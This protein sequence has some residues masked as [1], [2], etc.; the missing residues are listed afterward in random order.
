M[1]T[2]ISRFVIC[3]TI[4]SLIGW[5]CECAWCSIPDRK[6]VNRGFLIGPVCPIYGFGGMLVVAL[7]TPAAGNLLALFL[8]AA[9]ITTV[10]E[11]I[12]SVLMER[13]FHMRWWD[14][15]HN[16]FNI[17]G[18]VCLLNTAMFGIMGV[19]L[20]RVIHPFIASLVERLP[21]VWSIATGAAIALLFIADIF[22]SVRA[23]LQLSD[24]LSQL[25]QAITDF[26]EKG[27]E[28]RDALKARLS[29]LIKIR[30][31]HRRLI[32]AF[33]QMKSKFYPAAIERLREA[34]KNR[35]RG[36]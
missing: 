17:H 24:R 31:L 14:Y 10:L 5:A 35:K 20:M 34:V 26:K 3:F 9:V 22:L 32:N 23:T 30:F 6:F 18:R 13:L 2:E 11:Y 29:E 1:L 27:R 4:Y 21:P 7:L 28:Q 8:S 19:L 12:T 15:S 36:S 16:K 25:H 33:P